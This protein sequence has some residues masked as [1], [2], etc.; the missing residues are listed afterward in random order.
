M[1]GYPSEPRIYFDHNAS[2]PLRDEAREA[3][4]AALEAGANPSSVHAEGRAGRRLI[5]DAREEVAALVGA[6]PA[7]VVFTSGAAGWQRIHVYG[8]EHESVLAPIR[9]SGAK[10]E[11][12][13]VERDG[14]ADLGEFAR[15]VLSAE[16]L[17]PRTLL[18]L[19]MANSETGV[20]QDVAAA[21]SFAREQ[22][23]AVH[24]DAVQAAG[25]LAV[26]FHDLNVDYLT[27]SSHKLG[28]PMGV[29]ALVI[30]DGLMLPSL[31]KGGGQERR[32]RAGTENVAAIAGFG[33]AARVARGEVADMT[34]LGQLRDRL[35]AGIAEIVPD[36]VVIAEQSQRLANTLSV[37]LPGE[38]AET[39]VIKLDLA[40]IAVSVGSACSSGKVGASHVLAAMGVDERLAR[41]TIR[42]SLGW[43]TTVDDVEAFLER[44]ARLRAT[45]SRRVA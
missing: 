13:P 17:P 23:I 37:A 24:T 1:T 36:S 26:D 12:L 25:R 35:A 44:L 19:Q 5:E 45:G 22:G 4:I 41:S 11:E 3:M 39:S 27:I 29:G 16:T 43:S 34:G 21:A 2:A 42:L 10:I 38:L 9:A 28:G 32:R 20:V 14:A 30:R 15:R 18:T 6:T 33:A 31:I 7:E 8:F 40:G